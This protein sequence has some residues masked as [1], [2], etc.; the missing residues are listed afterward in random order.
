MNERDAYE[1]VFDDLK[2]CHMFTGIYD[3]KNG[4]ESFMHG[5]CTVMEFIANKAGR[6]DFIDDFIKNMLESERKANDGN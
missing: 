2:N 3:A 6:E 5:I 4:N 1:L